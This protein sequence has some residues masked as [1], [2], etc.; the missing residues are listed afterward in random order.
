[1]HVAGSTVRVLVGRA[2]RRLQDEPAHD[3]PRALHVEGR[4]K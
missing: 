2:R 3:P 1:M 4:G